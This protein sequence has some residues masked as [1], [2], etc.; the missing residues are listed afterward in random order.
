LSGLA[1]R[2]AHP[3][4]IALQRLGRVTFTTDPSRNLDEVGDGG[5]RDESVAPWPLGSGEST[6]PIKRG[7]E[8][9]ASK[10][11]EADRELG[12]VCE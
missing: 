6:Q 3:R 7:I 2:T 8:S 1:A 11:N 12:S 5:E 10:F 9:P 4:C